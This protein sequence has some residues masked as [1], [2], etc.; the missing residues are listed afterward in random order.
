[1]TKNEAHA[2]VQEWAARELSEHGIRVR[3]EYVQ[4]SQQRWP[5]TVND[6]PVANPRRRAWFR[7]LLDDDSGTADDHLARA[8]DHLRRR[9]EEDP[10]LGGVVTWAEEPDTDFH[11]KRDERSLVMVGLTIDET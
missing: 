5:R 6:E 8:A 2:A 7:V 10:P 11:D 1:M 4:S 9:A 3:V